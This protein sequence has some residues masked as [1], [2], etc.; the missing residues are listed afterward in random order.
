M[1]EDS[2]AK[3]LHYMLDT[4][5]EDRSKASLIDHAIAA[6]LEKEAAVIFT[7]MSDFTNRVHKYGI[8]QFLAAV[9]HGIKLAQ[10]IIEKHGGKL[11]KLDGD[12][13][14][15]TFG[16]VPSAVVSAR[17]ISLC[18]HEFNSAAPEQDRIEI[19]FGIGYGKILMTEVDAY[20]KEVNIASKLGEDIA[21][22][23]EILLT[24]TAYQQV[25][26]QWVFR[27]SLSIDFG[28]FKAK[29]YKLIRE[30]GHREAGP[31]KAAV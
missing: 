8:I 22:P 13:L 20:G 19:S 5:F 10:P 16:D 14:L 17:E 12:S 26:D 24:E 2:L 15:L 30:I 9:H 6:K 25:K 7:D 4:R 27:E 31:H 28:S 23:G 3:Y 18:F 1:V 21:R 11:L 29:G